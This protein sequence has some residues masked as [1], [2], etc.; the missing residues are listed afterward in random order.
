MLVHTKRILEYNDG[1]IAINPKFNKLVTSLRTAVEREGKL[2]KEITAHN[3]LFDSFR[4]SFSYW[5]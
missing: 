5:N 2:D 3:D 4:M 1:W